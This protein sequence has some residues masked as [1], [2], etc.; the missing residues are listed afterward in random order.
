MYLKECIESKK[1]E[2]QPSKQTNKQTNE[3]KK[4]IVAVRL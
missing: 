2:G 3:D 1:S 4:T